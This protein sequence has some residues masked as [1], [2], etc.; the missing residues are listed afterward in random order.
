MEFVIQIEEMETDG[1]KPKKDVKI[2]DC[3]EIPR[4]ILDER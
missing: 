3:G 2:A 1:E 4:N